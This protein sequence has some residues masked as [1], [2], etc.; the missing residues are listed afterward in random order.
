MAKRQTFSR[1]AISYSNILCWFIATSNIFHSFSCPRRFSHW[2]TQNPCTPSTVLRQ[3][4]QEIKWWKMWQSR[5]RP[6]VTLSKSTLQFVIAS[7]GPFMRRKRDRFKQINLFPLNVLCLFFFYFIFRGP[8]ENARLAEE[9]YQRLIAH[10]AENPTMGEVGNT[11]VFNH[12]IS[13]ILR[14][15][16]SNL[17][18]MVNKMFTLLFFL[19]NHLSHVR[20]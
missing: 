10:K 5:L 17:K 19:L 20:E 14:C 8:E 7:M 6:C 1:A 12:S 16:I 9:V 18:K 11:L 2:M 3:M 15:V 4:K 13:H